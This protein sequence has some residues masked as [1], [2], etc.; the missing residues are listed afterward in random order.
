MKMNTKKLTTK[1]IAGLLAI[2]IVLTGVS[3]GE[4]TTVNAATNGS[5][6]NFADLKGTTVTMKVGDTKAINFVEFLEYGAMLDD[7]N[8]YN[9][10]TSDASIVSM[11]NE[12][13]V[14]P[15]QV[16]TKIDYFIIK[17]EK[18]G[19]ATITATGKSTGT[20]MS[21]TVVVKAPEMTAKQRNCTHKWKVT[22]KAT[23]LRSGMKVCKKCKLEKVV[24]KK[25]HVFVTKTETKTTYKEYVVYVCNSCTSTDPEIERY[26]NFENPIA[27]HETCGM[28]FSA[29]AYGSESAARK[30]YDEHRYKHNDFHTVSMTFE[31]G[32]PQTKKVKVTRCKTCH[33][34]PEAI[35]KYYQ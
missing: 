35:E 31:Y 10:S 14:S 13:K 24:A 16:S 3:I 7:T 21:F 18:A 32:D 20:T 6:E 1:V 15:D 33:N 28:E 23:C 17:A 4:K 8:Y 12:Y 26:H 27:C 11:V 34:T 25:K 19:T 30:A 9:W 22:K 29:K 5:I 2:A